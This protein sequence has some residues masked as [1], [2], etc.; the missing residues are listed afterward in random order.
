MNLCMIIYTNKYL[1][2]IH[3]YIYIYI[4]I[5]F[6]FFLKDASK[7]GQKLREEMTNVHSA[8]HQQEKEM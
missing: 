5:F 1:I 7:D 4:Y 6:F 2:Y 8:M 3:I